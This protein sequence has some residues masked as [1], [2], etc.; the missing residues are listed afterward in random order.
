VA[1][2]LTG[3]VAVAF[4]IAAFLLGFGLP[5]VLYG[6]G[7][8][9]IEG[10]PEAPMQVNNLAIDTAFLQH[11]FRSSEPVALRVLNPWTYA[12]SLVT[13][14]TNLSSDD[15]SA[16]AWVV[17][18]NY[19][20]NHLKD[21]RMTFWH[22]SGAALT[23]WV[24]RHWT[25]EQ[26]VTAAAAITRSR[27]TPHFISGTSDEDL[28]RQFEENRAAY[29]RLRDLLVDDVSLRNVGRSGVQMEDSPIYVAPPTALISIAKY[30]EYMD[31]LKS[32]GGTRASRS[33]GLHPAIC[34]GVA[35]EGWAG[36]TRHKNICWRDEP[37]AKDSRFTD[38]L[39]ERS[40]Y[41]EKD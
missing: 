29:D 28:V 24:S 31:L 36:D 7:L 26:I 23:I 11:A 32:T 4:L 5:I 19:N 20:S 1:R 9:N 41:L 6:I 21:H 33:V 10:R 34:I 18:R 13:D 27:P 8:S 37:L 25:A 15:G 12:A 38:K 22:L 3:K 2:S 14:D 17:A 39:I 16:A 30:Q 35:A 40:W